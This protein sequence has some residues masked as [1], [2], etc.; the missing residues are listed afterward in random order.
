MVTV[1]G[2]GVADG[3]E[4]TWVAVVVVVVV[5]AVVAVVVATWVVRVEAMR[6]VL[7]SQSRP[8]DRRS[9]VPFAVSARYVCPS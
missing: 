2:V 3:W 5:V 7:S 9:L 1:A 4:G 6:H 8:S